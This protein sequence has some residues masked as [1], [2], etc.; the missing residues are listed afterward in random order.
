MR[1]YSLKF[2]PPVYCIPHTC[3]YIMIF[4]AEIFNNIIRICEF[5]NF[6][7]RNLMNIFIN[8]HCPWIV[9]FD[10]L[11]YPNYWCACYMPC[12]WKKNIITLHSFKTS[13]NIWNSVGS[14][15]SNMHR[16]TRI[17]ICDCHKYFLFIIWIRLKYI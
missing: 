6:F 2:P 17:W 11:G 14:S 15:M 13:I 3:H 8:I 1:I 5:F 7:F 12:H 4:R 10:T 9:S 16:A